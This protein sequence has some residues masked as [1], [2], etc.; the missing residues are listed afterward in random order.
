MPQMSYRVV[1]SIP[2]LLA[3][4]TGE[5]LNTR[6]MVVYAPKSDWRVDVHGWEVNRPKVKICGIGG[7]LRSNGVGV[8]R[9]E[10]QSFRISRLV[11]EAFHGRAPRGRNDCDHKNGDPSDNRAVNLE[12]VSRSENMLRSWRRRRRSL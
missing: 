3:S 9:L 5:I 6:T 10:S 1:P 8:P 4:S 2:F 12:W 7:V 11:C